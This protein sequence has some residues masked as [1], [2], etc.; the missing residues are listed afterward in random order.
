MYL[1]FITHPSLSTCSSFIFLCKFAYMIM[2]IRF[3]ELQK[4]E[5]QNGRHDGKRKKYS[6]EEMSPFPTVFFKVELDLAILQEIGIL[7]QLQFSTVSL[8][9]V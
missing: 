7:Q 9:A 8:F 5:L 2:A 3:I 4:K 6:I 1:K